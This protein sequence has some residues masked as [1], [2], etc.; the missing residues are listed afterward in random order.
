M[1]VT[2][3]VAPYWPRRFAHQVFEVIDGRR[4]EDLGSVFTEDCVY[5]RPG[6]P[7][8]VGLA[9]IERFYRVDRIIASGRHDIDTVMT[10]GDS[11]A[12]WGRFTGLSRTGE[13]LDERFSDLY[14]VEQGRIS[15]RR[16]YFYRA[17][18]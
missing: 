11:V 3:A 15:E 6:Y 12:C 7:P 18:I 9:E 5:H 14:R 2:A 1:D 17:A 10:G 16:T 4:W 13:R 8:L